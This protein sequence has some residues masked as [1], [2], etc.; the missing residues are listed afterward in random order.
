MGRV[1]DYIAHWKNSRYFKPF[2]ITPES[3]F[4]RMHDREIFE[5]LRFR[6]SLEAFVYFRYRGLPDMLDESGSSLFLGVQN[7]REKLEDRNW[8]IRGPG[9]QLLDILDRAIDSGTVEQDSIEEVG[10]LF[11]SASFYAFHYTPYMRYWIRAMGHAT[12]FLK[13]RIFREDFEQAVAMG[14][15][16][17]IELYLLLRDDEFDPEVKHHLQIASDFMDWSGDV[18]RQMRKDEG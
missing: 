8:F 15:V 9:L 7:I 5:I 17:F 11:N 16:P 3:F 1:E 18:F 10:T 4:V 13:D 6:D 12:T 14:N 2:A